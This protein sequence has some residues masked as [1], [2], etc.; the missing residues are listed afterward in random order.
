MGGHW[1]ISC[2]QMV[3][4]R[5]QSFGYLRD[6]NQNTIDIVI[7]CLSISGSLSF[8]TYS[9]LLH[10]GPFQEVRNKLSTDPALNHLC[11]IISETEEGRPPTVFNELTIRDCPDMGNISTHRPFTQSREQSSVMG[12]R[13]RIKQKWEKLEGANIRGMGVDI[14]GRYQQ[15]K[16]LYGPNMLPHWTPKGLTHRSSKIALA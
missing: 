16:P 5:K 13:T 6:Q 12:S 10:K 4:H 14:L 15:W 1:G 8:P 11:L 7:D 9:L 3:Y 2:N